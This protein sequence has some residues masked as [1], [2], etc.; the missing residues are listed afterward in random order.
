MD[1]KNNR[2]KKRNFI[3]QSIIIS[4]SVHFF[5]ALIFFNMHINIKINGIKDYFNKLPLLFSIP[6]FIISFFV[7][8]ILIITIH[9][10]FE[11]K[12]KKSNIYHRM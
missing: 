7:V 2:I 8:S 3:K 9:W 6:I 11:R 1:N 12:N 4:F 5:L 10:I